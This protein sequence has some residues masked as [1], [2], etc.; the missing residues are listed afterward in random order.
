MCLQSD[1]PDLPARVLSSF[2][3][4]EILERYSINLAA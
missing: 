3:V 1:Q 2:C 4:A